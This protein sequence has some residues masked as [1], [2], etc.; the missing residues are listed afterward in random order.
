MRR[1][2]PLAA[3]VLTAPLAPPA[4]GLGATGSG[5][6]AGAALGPVGA[7]VEAVA[8]P[9]ALGSAVGGDGTLW[10]FAPG[11]R[12]TLGP[13]LRAGLAGPGR[14]EARPPWDAVAAD[15]GR[16]CRVR[17]HAADADAVFVSVRL[18]DGRRRRALLLRWDVATGR[19]SEVRT[20]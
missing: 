3:L 20:L 15:G 8:A 1:A 18:R 13:G 19:W 11:W 10:A 16:E 17:T 7:S 6:A 5:P 12:V 14:A 4:A 9:L 2:L